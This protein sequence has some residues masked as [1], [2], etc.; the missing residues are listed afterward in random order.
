MK[1]WSRWDDQKWGQQKCY[2]QQFKDTKCRSNRNWDKSNRC[3]I[4]ISNFYIS[5]GENLEATTKIKVK[6][7][8]TTYKKR[9]FDDSRIANIISG[10]DLRTIWNKETIEEKITFGGELRKIRPNIGTKN[11]RRNQIQYEKD[12]RQETRVAS[13]NGKLEI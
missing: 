4:C 13:M 6:K 2:S 3:K 11:T 12:K 8:N 10:D 5:K 7:K 9:W 1:E